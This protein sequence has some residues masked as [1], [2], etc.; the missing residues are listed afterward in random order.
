[1]SVYGRGTKNGQYIRQRNSYDNFSRIGSC[2]PSSPLDHAFEGQIEAARNKVISED[3]RKEREKQKKK[4][5]VSSDHKQEIKNISSNKVFF[6]INFPEKTN[7]NAVLA[8]CLI[9][10]ISIFNL[11]LLVSKYDPNDLF[12]LVSFMFNFL[13]FMF[14]TADALVFSIFKNFITDNSFRFVFLFIFLFSSID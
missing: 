4:E 3:L 5:E 7:K 2:R 8:S 1:M 14:F 10:L 9:S 6:K 13:I 11:F 12:V